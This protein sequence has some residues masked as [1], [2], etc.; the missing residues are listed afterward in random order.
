MTASQA[1]QLGLWATRLLTPLAVG[2]G[3]VEVFRLIFVPSPN[4]IRVEG[5]I[6]GL[7]GGHYSW[8]RDEAQV[9]VSYKT[10]DGEQR[11]FTA[12]RKGNK[13]LGPQ[14]QVV[15]TVLPDDN[16]TID[17]D[18]LPGRPANDN[19]PKL[20]PRPK[21]D[22]RTNDKGL[23]YEA[24]MRPL[25]NPF[26]PTPLGSA[27]YLPNPSTGK[28]VEFDDCEQK[29]GTMVDYKDRYWD[30]LRKPGISKLV[31]DDL[32]VQALRQISA[33]GQRPVR[34]YFAEKK[35]QIS[36]AFNFI[37]TANSGQNRYRSQ[38]FPR[39]TIMNAQRFTYSIWL[40]R[41][42]RRETPAV[43]GQKFLDT[44]DA[45]SAADP[46]FT[47]W[48]VLDKPAMAALPRATARPRDRASLRSL[49]TTSFATTMA[50]PSPRS[51]I[52]RSA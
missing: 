5:D 41:P 11:T 20:C 40:V 33:A 25:V 50:N 37:S 38:A 30:M 35:P 23:E 48:R 17:S 44:L 43:I 28:A 29:S 52:A 8:N 3:A 32:L 10:A 39:K 4:R 13:F 24:F 51:A 26:M 45:L 7:P 31:M 49:K 21:P 47:P 2:A 15:G 22:K 27:Y 16:V 36:C 19:E 6:A 9:H 14:G 46:L 1:E 18:A 42:Q 34:W 12:Q